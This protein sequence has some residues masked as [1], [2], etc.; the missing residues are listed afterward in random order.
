MAAR[1][2]LRFPKRFRPA[3]MA[4]A[5]L[6]IAAAAWAKTGVEGP[7][8]NESG[9]VELY[10]TGGVFMH[11]ILLCSVLGPAIILERLTYF[12]KARTD[13]RRPI[14]ELLPVLHDLAF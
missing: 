1:L 3:L 4:F 11:P 7:I 5:V 8:P 14:G 13:T 12:A 2:K 6:L 10:V 9:L